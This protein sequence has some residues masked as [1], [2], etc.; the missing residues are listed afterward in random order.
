[1]DQIVF[2]SQYSIYANLQTSKKSKEIIK[3]LTKIKKKE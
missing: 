1:M 3:E 2:Y